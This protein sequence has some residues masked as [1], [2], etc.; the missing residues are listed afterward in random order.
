MAVDAVRHGGEARLD[1]PAV[2]LQGR[3]LGPTVPE[4]DAAA[5]GVRVDGP[6]NTLDVDVPAVGRQLHG[7]RPRHPHLVSDVAP[8]L[9]AP[10]VVRGELQ[11]AV[12]ERV[13]GAGLSL[14]VDEAF[15][16]LDPAT[17]RV[18]GDHVDVAARSRHVQLRRL[19]L[20]RVGLL[21]V[22]DLFGQLA[23]GDRDGHRDEG[24]RGQRD[25]GGAVSRPGGAACGHGG[26]PWNGLRRARAGS[27]VRG[28]RR[29]AGRFH[30]PAPRVPSPSPAGTICP[31]FP[32]RVSV[33]PCQ[34]RYD[35]LRVIS[36]NAIRASSRCPSR[37]GWNQSQALNSAPVK[38]KSK[39]DRS[40]RHSL[41]RSQ[42]DSRALL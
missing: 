22:G 29:R 23:A 42:T 9:D 16:H 1:V 14:A 31:A 10:A 17:G 39:T 12:V 5:T 2:G 3:L 11:R 20:H 7:G 27:G 25:A 24:G 38:R 36:W 21:A 26:S 15:R 28:A 40:K 4:V 37:P 6:H 34:G 13:P 19:P 41:S 33:P 32:L 18:V 30:P 35:P 8:A